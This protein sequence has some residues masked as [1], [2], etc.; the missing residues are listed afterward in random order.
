[1]EFLAMIFDNILVSLE[2]IFIRYN[3]ILPLKKFIEH[4]FVNRDLFGRISLVWDEHTIQHFNDD[5]RELLDALCKEIEQTLGK[6]SYSASGMIITRDYP[7]TEEKQRAVV[8]TYG[9]NFPFTVMDRLPSESYWSRRSE[10]TTKPDDEISKKMTVFYSIKGGVGR[11]T[12]LAAAAWYFA[13]QGKK[14]MVLDMDLESPGLSS[15]LLPEDRQPEYGLLDWLVEDVVRNGDEVVGNLS[16]SSPL[17]N[18]SGIRGEIIV[19]PAHGKSMTEYVTKMGRAWMPRMGEESRLAWPQRLRELIKKLDSIHKPDCIF[20]DARAGLDEISSAC[21]LD[22][23]PHT[24]LLFAQEGTQTWTGY[25]ILFHYWNA[26]GQ[27]R[28]I[29]ETLKIVAAMIPPLEDKRSYVQGLRENAWKCFSTHLYDE[30]PADQQA[31]FS[32]DLMDEQAPHTPWLI[33]W[34]QG[35]MAMQRLDTLD[36]ALDPNLMTATFPFVCSLYDYIFGED[37]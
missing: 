23:A 20:I 1:M 24:V 32:Y 31:S 6:H 15:S 18:G 35:L 17:A 16:A 7:F 34:Y 3:K 19:I 2:K 5:E 37:S 22:L 27:A 4:F 33:H 36:S 21:V 30:L 8:F 9:N 29:R 25:S 12:A 11:S 26:V 13:S 10:N 28:D 14:V